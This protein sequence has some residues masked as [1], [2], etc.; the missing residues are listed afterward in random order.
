MQEI[1]P[2]KDKEEKGRRGEDRRKQDIASTRQ[3][4]GRILSNG[5]GF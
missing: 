2:P 4:P 3:A 1:L 5:I